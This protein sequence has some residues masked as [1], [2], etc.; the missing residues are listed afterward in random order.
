MARDTLGGALAIAETLPEDLGTALV[1]AAQVAFIDA[2]HFVAA[3]AAILAVLAAIGAAAAL[4][5][6][7]ARPEP[8]PEVDTPEPVAAGG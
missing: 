4:R 5:G 8:A 6:V 1:A 2:I 3:V 7:P